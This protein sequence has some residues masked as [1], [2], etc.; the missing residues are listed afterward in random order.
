[1]VSLLTGLS[2][3][4]AGPRDLAERRILSNTAVC[5]QLV[6]DISD[7]ERCYQAHVPTG[8]SIR[9]AEIS[10]RCVLDNHWD[11]SWE[12]RSLVIHQ[13]RCLL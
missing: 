13:P 4:T 3:P 11:L 5:E 9:L 7:D 2:S 1:M 12:F 6:E 8:C 10:C